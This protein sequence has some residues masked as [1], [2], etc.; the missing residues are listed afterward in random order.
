MNSFRSFAAQTVQCSKV[1]V[2]KEEYEFRFRNELIGTL[3]FSSAFKKRAEAQSADGSWIVEER[4]FWEPRILVSVAGENRPLIEIPRLL[5]ALIKIRLP[6]WRILR[7]KRDFWKGEHALKTDMNF[8]LL[9]MKGRKG[10]KSTYQIAI[11]SRA[12]KLAELPWLVFVVL[13][14]VVSEKGKGA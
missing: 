6:G 4:G 2:L 10:L 13:F 12:G 14:A 7:L 11:D 1:S 8:P 5:A 9:T 3:K